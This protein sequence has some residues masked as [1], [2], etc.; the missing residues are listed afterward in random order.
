M[1]VDRG[2]FLDG[3]QPMFTLY[4]LSPPTFS[5]VV[6]SILK[7]VTFQVFSHFESLCIPPLTSYFA[8]AGESSPPLWAHVFNWVH[9]HNPGFLYLKVNCAI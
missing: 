6:P 4:S 2:R 7:E 9:L 8:T 5:L 3:C 1:A